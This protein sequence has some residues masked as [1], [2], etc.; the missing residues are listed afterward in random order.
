MTAALYTARANLSPLVIEG[1]DA[2]GQLMMTTHVENFPGFKD[3]I[4]GPDLMARFREQA[5]RFGAEFITA[6]AEDIDLAGPPFTV[7]A[8][9]QEIVARSMIITTGAQ[10]RMLEL[11]AEERLLGHGVELHQR[12]S[13]C[14]SAGSRFAVRRPRYGGVTGYGKPR[15]HGTTVVSGR[16]QAASRWYGNRIL[17]VDVGSGCSG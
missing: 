13:P 15:K 10:A 17:V 8:A 7:R 9:G 4:L 16:H 11:P 2:G 3:G 6:D 12:D 14:P 1:L 5:E